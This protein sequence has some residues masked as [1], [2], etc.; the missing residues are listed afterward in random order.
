MTHSAVVWKQPDSIHMNG[1]AHK[2]LFTTTVSGLILAAGCSLPTPDVI[3]SLFRFHQ[4]SSNVFFDILLF[5]T[6]LHLVVVPLQ[7]LSDSFSNVLCLVSES[8][9]KVEA[10]CSFWW[11]CF[12]RQWPED[13]CHCSTV[14]RAECLS[15]DG[16]G[17][18]TY[19][20]VCPRIHPSPTMH[21][22]IHPSTHPT[23]LKTS[24]L[25][26]ISSSVQHLRIQSN[27][28]SFL[29]L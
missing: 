28:S 16:T 10:P 24:L 15:V 27:A 12:R 13:G 6:E 17:R 5:I 25:C 3:C 9:M 19:V 23:I 22:S 18:Y 20:P 29:E 1:R 8:R 11:R 2:A 14:D 7:F 26:S 4:L 21:S